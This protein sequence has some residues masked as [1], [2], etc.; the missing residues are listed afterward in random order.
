MDNFLKSDKPAFLC[1]SQEFL[2]DNLGENVLLFDDSMN[3][4]DIQEIIN[5][6]HER[7]KDQEF[8]SDRYALLFKPGTYDLEIT[9]DYYVQASG[10]G[11]SPGHVAITGT[12]QSIATTKS[13]NV[14]TMFWR[15][16]ENFT[17]R[18]FHRN[19]PVL[20]AVSQ[21]APYRR[22]HI[23]G[24]LLFD[25]N[26]WASGG[27]LSNSLVEGSAG[28]PSGQQWFSMNSEMRDWVGAHWNRTFL[29]VIGAPRENWPEEPTSVIDSTPVS[30]EKPFLCLN[31]IDEM[32]VFVPSLRRDEKG[33][34]WKR[35]DEDGSWISLD[36]FYIAKPEIDSDLTI[37]RA[38]EKGQHLLLTPGI[39]ELNNPIVV[40]VDDTVVLGLGMAT[41]RPAI[42]N[43]A[44]LVRGE[45]GIII[46]GLLVD[47]GVEKSE[48][49][50][51]VGEEN[52][53]R[54]NSENPISLHDIFCR[55]GGATAGC[56]DI[57]MAIFSDHVILD[58]LWLWRADHGSGVGWE[59]NSCRNGLVVYGDDVVA[60]GLFCEHFQEYQ[61]LWYG[62]RGKT[63]FYQSELPYDPPDQ[64]S[65]KSSGTMGYSSYKVVHGVKDHMAFGLGIYAFLGIKN[66]TDKNVH[67]ENAVETPEEP[68]IKISHITTFSKGYGRINHCLNGYG[69]VTEPE[70][71]QFY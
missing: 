26:G 58:H 57:C 67:L 51:Q 59:E 6:I 70:S 48:I 40:A 9:V 61:T 20:W 4:A 41:L 25:R 28:T 27:F 37:N 2:T 50:V 68:G 47:A 12:V 21:A 7:Q 30:R 42:G 8:S 36:R 55:I 64:E 14:T 19:E 23:K 44:L 22:M 65:W 24:D 46:A 18:P 62:E 15:S 3:M 32:G 31:K 43:S 66:N 17:V 54:S 1:I 71:N 53:K 16:A 39:Y 45:E 5:D 11:F 69:E 35:G 33:V 13:N 60:Y 63:Y 10:L 34:S 56:A 29:G 49:L 38:L 52:S